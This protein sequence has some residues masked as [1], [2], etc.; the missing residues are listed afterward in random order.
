MRSRIGVFT[1]AAIAVVLSISTV[2][3]AQSDS[4][5]CRESKCSGTISGRVLDPQKRVVPHAS[6]ALS[7]GD[8]KTAISLETTD[9]GEYTFRDLPPGQYTL[10]VLNAG[11]AEW[12][13]TVNVALA[14]RVRRDVVL[15][16]ATVQETVDVGER[17]PM[18]VDSL[19]L[20]EVRE[21]SA[22]DVG[23]ALSRLDGVSKIRKGGIANDVVLRGFQQ[24]N[25]N[26][27]ID[28]AR[29]Y[30]ACPGHMDPATQHVDFAEVE[31][32][33]VIKGAFDVT[34]MG[35]LGG[36]VNVISKEA[37]NGLR[38]KPSFSSGSFGFYNPAV[39]GS[40]GSDRFKLLLGYSYR[41]SEPY[42]DGSGRRFTDYVSY[43][44][45]AL[46][47]RAF[48]INTGW[49]S[50]SFSPTANQT[51]SLA[52]T[53]QQSG[54]VLYPYLMMDSDYDNAD[55][56][57]VKY[58]ARNVAP[59]LKRLRAE[60]YFT[61]VNHFM[62]D[63]QRASAGTNPWKMASRATSRAIGG[64]VEADVS[65]DLT[66][67]VESYYR[68]WNVLGYMRMMATMMTSN[69]VPDVDTRTLGAFADYRHSFTDR[70][71]LSGGL[72]FDHASMSVTNPDATTDL[73][74]AYKGTRRTSNMDNYPSGNVRLSFAAFRAGEVFVGVGSTAR[75]PD[76]EERYISRKN[77]MGDNVGNPL[78]PPTRNTEFTAGVNLKRGGSYIK[79]VLF[80]SNLD[81]Y[82][83]L[84]RQPRINLITM[85]GMTARSYENVDARI[86][87][88]EISYAV[89][90]KNSVSVSGGTSY[91]RGI[92]DR[93]PE[94][95]VIST[96]LAEMP[97]LRSWVALRY[98]RNATFVEL[99]GMAAGRQG[100]VDTDLKETATAG[101]GTMNFK[102]GTSYKKLSGMLVVDNLLNR[103][104]YEHLSYYRDPYAS[105]VK[106]PEPGRSC[107]AQ[108][109]YTF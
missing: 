35:S 28:G 67:G 66:F 109:S 20:G 107:F 65:R 22:K 98:V 11:F 80:Y 52:Y 85:P 93:K 88:G 33:E 7:G 92:R 6:V 19:D 32:V 58:M 3:W 64:K 102:L 70:L 8:A 21:S 75:I 62:S 96:N 50:T 86:Y 100:R 40:Y 12:H 38:I 43:N 9:T 57:S 5:Q 99:G 45:T 82:I 95:G 81:D 49:F 69:S 83:V 77:S 41:T 1:V 76:A 29:I 4:A 15:Q 68:N 91:S 37:G 71:R 44:A 104:Y 94:A 47:R 108:V 14:E 53:R 87:G 78:L 42:K 2:L 39:T 55:R 72:R 84:D 16:L 97:P 105:G 74:Y 18:V 10:E 59:G 106:V 89:A 51:V 30:G 60:T 36:T 25:V 63:S 34:N 48:D 23:E 26:V 17:E 101:Y 79:P 61:Q 27:V 13:G 56:A 103:Y 46:N 54:L 73:Y 31:R 24:N 90:L